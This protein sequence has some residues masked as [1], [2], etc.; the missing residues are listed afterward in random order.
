MCQLTGFY[1]LIRFFIVICSVV[2]YLLFSCVKAVI[3]FVTY[4]YIYFLNFFY[5]VH[6]VY[7]FVVNKQKIYT[8]EAP[9]HLN[10]AVS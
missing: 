6:A 5:L 3:S 4:F 1:P 10:M 9:G 2:V 7:Y 8:E